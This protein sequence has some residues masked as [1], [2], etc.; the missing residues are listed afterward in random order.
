MTLTMIRATPT[1]IPGIIPPRNSLPIDTLAATP[2]TTMGMLGGIIT[3]MVELVA[4]T[5][6]VTSAS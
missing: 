4:V 6:T 3:P 2:N 5:A 1:S